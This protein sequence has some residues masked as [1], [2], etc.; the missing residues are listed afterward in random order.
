MFQR[1]S[2]EKEISTTMNGNRN[3]IGRSLLLIVWGPITSA[4]ALWELIKNVESQRSH[5]ILT[6]LGPAL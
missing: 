4:V 2:S 1:D 5:P 6:E 3:L